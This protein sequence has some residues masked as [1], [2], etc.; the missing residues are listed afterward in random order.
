MRAYSFIQSDKEYMKAMIPP[1]APATTGWHIICQVE[2][3]ALTAKL[4]PTPMATPIST[5]KIIFIS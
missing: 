1:K 2:P 4:A 5:F 3:D